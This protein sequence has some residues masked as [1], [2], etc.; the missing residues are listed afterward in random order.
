MNHLF[1]SSPSAENLMNT[2][3]V[4]LRPGRFE[5]GLALQF[6]SGQYSGWPVVD[7]TREILGVVTELRLLQACSRVNSLDELMVEDTMSTPVFVFEQD[8]LDVVMKLMVQSQVLRM[9]VVRERQLVGVISRGDV[10]RYSLPLSSPASQFVFSCGWCERVYDPS[11]RLI[12]TDD[13][14]TLDAY[15]SSHQLTFSD[16]E[17]AQT[18]CPS[19]LEILQALQTTSHGSSRAGTVV[20]QEVRP[21]LLVVDDDPSIAGLLVQALQEWGYEVLVARNGREGLDLLGGRCVDGILLDMHMPIMDGRTMLDELRWLGHQMPVLMMSGASE[22]SLLRRM[23]QEGAQGF[24]LKPFHLASVQQACRKIFQND[25]D[26][27]EV[28][29]RFH[30]A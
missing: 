17:P 4:P 14:Q 7:S 10:L 29:S 21:C 2:A 18:Y 27:A 1:S 5:K 22:T 30:V 9:P 28:S 11:E 26:K 25:E 6:L 12:G 23:L 8:P 16:I 19:C 24:F 13:W 3:A 20:H 15:L